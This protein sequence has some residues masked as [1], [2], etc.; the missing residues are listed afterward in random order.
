[1]YIETA[2]R[3]LMRVA[4]FLLCL[5][6]IAPLITSQNIDPGDRDFWNGKFKDPETVVQS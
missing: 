3:V 5:L 1:M 4:G 2:I 6:L